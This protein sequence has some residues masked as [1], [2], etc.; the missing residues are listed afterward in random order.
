MGGRKAVFLDLQG[1]LGG[2]G[3][4][5]ILRF[6]FFPCSIRAIKLLNRANLLPIIVTNQS[7]ISKGHLTLDQFEA[8][9]GE[10]KSS[11]RQ[12]VQEWMASTAALMAARRGCY[13]RK[14]SHRMLLQAQTDFDLNVTACY[15][16]GDT[17]PRD[18]SMAR[19]VGCKAVLVRTGR[20]EESLGP[21]RHRWIGIEPDYVA[22]DVLD[23]AQWIVSTEAATLRPVNTI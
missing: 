22:Q 15:V 19:S 8:R 3:L 16:V 7:Y 21:G 9:I 5:H 14:P 17:G 12:A 4:G 1:T 11:L 2:A 6:S 20:G 10:L 23:A 18:I 13:C